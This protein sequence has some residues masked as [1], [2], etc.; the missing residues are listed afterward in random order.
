MSHD[1]ES[2]IPLF[3]ND[4]FA[5]TCGIRLVELR[6]GFAKM[7]LGIDDRHLNRVGTVHGG[8]IFT[9]ADSASGAA[10]KTGGKA[11]VSVDTNISFVKAAKA[12]T[13]YA[14]ATEVARSRK[15]STCT[16]RVTDDAG[17]LVALFQG[18]AYIK[19]KPFPPEKTLDS[20]QAENQ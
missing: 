9:L 12:G 2:L 5:A 11:T 18:T 15:L 7:V 16:V 14:E 4:H 20:E 13:L 19:D 6:P 8:A 10:S 17:E 1:L 3:E